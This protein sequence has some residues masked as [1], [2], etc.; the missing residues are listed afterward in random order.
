MLSHWRELRPGITEEAGD[1][2]PF[3]SQGKPFDCPQGKETL[4]TQ[5]SAET[6]DSRR[7]GEG[8]HRRY[9]EFGVVG[10]EAGGAVGTDG[11]AIFSVI[12]ERRPGQAAWERRT[13][14]SSIPSQSS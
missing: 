8:Q 12:G 3:G 2:A 4:R 14:L 7:A 1:N 5:R 11:A 6:G 13:A 9:L 10:G